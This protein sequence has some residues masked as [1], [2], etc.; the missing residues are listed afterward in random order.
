MLLLLLMLL[1]KIERTRVEN[2]FVSK[3]SQRFVQGSISFQCNFECNSMRTTMQISLCQIMGE[4][5]ESCFQ[6]LFFFLSY[7]ISFFVFSSGLGGAF[8]LDG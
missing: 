1:S 5:L 3:G 2:N 6:V 8:Q 7:S 4:F